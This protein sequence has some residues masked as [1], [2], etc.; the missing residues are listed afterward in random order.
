MAKGEACEILETLDGGGKAHK[1][2]LDYTL[3]PEDALECMVRVF[4]INEP[5]HGERD[6]WRKIPLNEMDKHDLDHYYKAKKAERCPGHTVENMLMHRTHHAI[7]AV[8]GLAVFLQNT[9][10]G[11]CS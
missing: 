11:S 6:N 5:I 4:S 10:C 2:E 1:L 3:F 9:E 8:M 7:R